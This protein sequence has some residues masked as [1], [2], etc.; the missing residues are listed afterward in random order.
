MGAIHLAVAAG[1]FE[2]DELNEFEKLVVI[3]EL[4]PELAMSSEFVS[5]FLREVK[6]AARL[7]HGNIV[8]TI[9][10]G[11]IGE[12]Y[13]MAME[14]LDGQPFTKLLA[15]AS[16]KSRVPLRLR[17]QILCDALAGLHYAHELKDYDGT[18]LSVVHCD[19]SFGNVFITYEGQVKLVDFGVA[20]VADSLGR[21]RGFQGKVRYAAPE[22]LASEPVDRRADVFSAGILLWEILALRRYTATLKSERAVIEARL[23]GTEPKIASVLSHVDRELALISDRALERDPKKRFVSAEEFRL[24]LSGY[25]SKL[26]PRIDMSE[27]ARLMRMEFVEERGKIHQIISA[28][29][30]SLNE[31]AQ[32]GTIPRTTSEEALPVVPDH[33]PV[34]ESSAS[35]RVTV[36]SAEAI[37]KPRWLLWGLGLGLGMLTVAGVGGLVANIP[38]DSAQAPGLVPLPSTPGVGTSGVAPAIPSPARHQEP[39]IVLEV[40][41]EEPASGESRQKRTDGAGVPNA[42]APGSLGSA[43]GTSPQ[44]GQPQAPK[45]KPEQA[46]IDAEKSVQ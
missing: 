24:A 39:G 26:G 7:N 45:P 20:R 17:L 12:R 33:S 21:G 43:P 37:E 16:E 31:G 38:R 40:K 30:K 14:F 10:A 13:F 11:K 34:V 46:D 22:Q 35:T 8:Q 9:E 44:S 15:K 3:K 25:L 29:L 1:A 42:K 32:S 41:L 4:K 6:L 19:V 27:I 36:R 18:P 28:A 23:A 2:D 5:M